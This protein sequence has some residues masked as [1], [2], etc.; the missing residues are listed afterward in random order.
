VNYFDALAPAMAQ[1]RGLSRIDAAGAGDPVV[2]SHQA[3]VTVFNRDP[4]AVGRDLEIN[5]RRFT[6]V[7]VLAPAFS[8]LGDFPRDVF[9]LRTAWS[10]ASSRGGPSETR[11]TEIMVRLRPGVS[12][13]A[14]ARALTPVMATLV[15]A[16]DAVRADVRPQ[17]SPNAL[18]LEMLAIVSP[19]FAAFVLV[20]VTACANVSNVMLAR[21]IARHREIAVRLSIGASR[22]RIVRQL[23]TEGVLLAVL[24]GAGGLALAAWGLRLATLAIFSTLPP[25]VAPILRFAAMPLDAR[26][27]AFALAASAAATVLFALLPA[28]QAS[29]LSLIDALRGQGGAVRRGSRLRNALVVA[30]VAVALVLVVTALTLARN[31]AAVGRIDLGYDTAGILSINVRGEQDDLA[32]PLAVRLAADPRVAEIAV[33]SGNPLFNQGR[34]LAAAPATGGPAGRTPCTFVSPE[35]FAVLRIPIARGRGFRADEGQAAAHVAIV[36][37]ATA[38]AL[39]PTTD[40]IGKTI[41]IERA[42]GRPL[43]ELPDYPEVTVV[44]TVRDI[45]TG[46]MVNGHDGGHI[47]LPI[48]AADSHATA[49]LVRGRTPGDLQAEALQQIFR[50]VAP[51]PQIF[52]AVPLDDIRGLQVYPLRAASWVG[53]LL[54][55]IALV[56]SV[57]GLYGVLAYALSQRRKEIGIRIA[58][59]ATAR[60]VMTLVLR[61]S[62][63]LALIGGS[64]GAVVALAVLKV[65]DT[66]VH[67]AAISLLDGRSFVV[68]VGAVL[69]ATALAAYQPARRAARIDPAEMLRADA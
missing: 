28:L 64:I 27:F 29:R 23:L 51:D 57:S 55:G 39:W 67:L 50:E 13:D 63:R 35:F 47:Y 33:T 45:V 17:S 65:L 5:G 3:W 25:S 31:G 36:S 56:L 1:G 42:Q 12:A 69:A 9:L 53:V 30:Q 68:G 24:A 26:V 7:G 52:E 6:V 59:G 48:T 34:M 2:L 4:S 15:E 19:V 32:R 49:I 66:A 44:G 10:D 37:E 40:P 14:A 41:R 61:Q 20:L 43:D 46:I 18:S 21:A 38:A 62:G 8:G 22:G 58:L 11:E 54:G 16:K 60:S